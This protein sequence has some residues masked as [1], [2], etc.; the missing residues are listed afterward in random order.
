MARIRKSAAFLEKTERAY[1]QGYAATLRS[2]IAQVSG[3]AEAAR[4]WAGKAVVAFDRAGMSVHA[5]AL[6]MRSGKPD[7]RSVMAQEGIADPDRWCRIY[8][9][10]A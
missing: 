2:G 10:D 3:Q 1:A 5:A 9:P 8:L 4:H 6:L 7:A